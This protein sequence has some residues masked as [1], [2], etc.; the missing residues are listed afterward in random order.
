MT[1]GVK[2]LRVK[3]NGARVSGSNYGGGHMSLGEMFLGDIT[4][5][6][7]FFQPQAA[8]LP[9]STQQ[10]CQTAAWEDSD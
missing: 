6:Q 1:L 9:N 10:T 3:I 4:G 8:G 2:Y 7:M 5:V